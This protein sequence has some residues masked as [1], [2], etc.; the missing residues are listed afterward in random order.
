[1]DFQS[2]PI[3]GPSPAEPSPDKTLAAASVPLPPVPPAAA[4][5]AA[6]ET[7]TGPAARKSE[8]L[9]GA[10]AQLLG[11]Q[12]TAVPDT[13]EVSYRVSSTHDIVTV[14]TDQQTGKEIAQFPKEIIVEIASFFDTHSGVTLDSSA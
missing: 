3:S 7:A 11:S 9:T 4:T 5:Q 10:L 13:I 14:F 12:K 2:Q 8:P 1:M 6:D